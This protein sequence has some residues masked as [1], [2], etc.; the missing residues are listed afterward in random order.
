VGRSS[1]PRSQRSGPARLWRYAPSRRSPR[2]RR[3]DRRHAPRRARRRQ[4]RQRTQIAFTHKARPQRQILSLSRNRRLI[5]AVRQGPASQS[6]FRPI[7][8][9][10][11]IGWAELGIAPVVTRARPEPTP[12]RAI[13]HRSKR[14]RRDEWAETI[15]G[16][17]ATRTAS[18]AAVTRLPEGEMA[19]LSGHV[20]GR[21]PA[22]PCGACAHVSRCRGSAFPAT[23]R[24]GGKVEGRSGR[25]RPSP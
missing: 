19:V 4:H 20:F 22:R 2:I 17:G 18:L 16:I 24:P 21:D 6:I 9:R 12:R 5:A 13:R 11:Q 3:Q 15:G 25:S 7:T 10:M 14:R 23:W 8:L 1:A